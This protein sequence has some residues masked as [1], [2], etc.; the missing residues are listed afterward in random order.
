MRLQDY[1]IHQIIC[2]HL[3]EHHGDKFDLRQVPVPEPGP[4]KALVR[5]ISSGVCH[6]DVSSYNHIFVAMQVCPPFIYL[7]I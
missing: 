1:D 3:A 6:T 5:I 2:D 4:G 7:P